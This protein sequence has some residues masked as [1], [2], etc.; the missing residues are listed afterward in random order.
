MGFIVHIVQKINLRHLGLPTYAAYVVTATVVSHFPL[1]FIHFRSHIESTHL[2]HHW[3]IKWCHGKWHPDS[4]VGCTVGRLVINSDVPMKQ[5]EQFWKLE[6]FTTINYF[7]WLNKTLPFVKFQF[8]DIILRIN[9]NVVLW[10]YPVFFS[11]LSYLL[12][13][14]SQLG[15]RGD[16]RD[17]TVCLLLII[18]K[19]FYLTYS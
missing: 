2:S 1:I 4:L 12:L 9:C 7:L 16:A 13:F 8:S 6:S 5:L 18:S 15:V 3:L 10:H 14:S 19:L 17:Q 11:P